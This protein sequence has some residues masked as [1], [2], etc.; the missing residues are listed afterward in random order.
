MSCKPANW[1]ERILHR[2]RCPWREI[3]GRSPTREDW[4]CI[5]RKCPVCGSV[6]YRS[7]NTFGDLRWHDVDDA[8]GAS[9]REHIDILVS[10]R[11][12]GFITKVSEGGPLH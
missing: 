10:A 2:V 3:M 4:F 9:P 6:Q 5:L 1:F 12:E 7:F 11:Y 8:S